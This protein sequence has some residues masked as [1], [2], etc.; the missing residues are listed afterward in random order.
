VIAYAAAVGAGL[1][2]TRRYLLGRL[3]SPRFAR[4]TLWVFAAMLLVMA[5][6][7][8]IIYPR[9]TAGA[10]GGGTDRDE[11]LNI[12]VHELL[13]GRY[14]YYPRTYLNGPISPLPGSLL[15]A[16]PF[17]LL[18]ESAYQNLFW[19]AATFWVLARRCGDRSFA[20]LVIGSV[21]ALSP[22][23]WQELLT[24][25]DLL[26]NSLFVFVFTLLA[27]GAYL[28]RDTPAWRR[29]AATLLLGLSLSSRAN[30]G[31]VLLPLVALHARARGGRS[32]LGH[33]ALA[34]ATAAVITV[35]FYLYDPAGFSPLHTLG[36]V[37]SLGPAA[38]LLAIAA[39]AAV[40]LLL[41]LQPMHEIGPRF[42]LACAGPQAIPVAAGMALHPL[43]GRSNDVF[44]G[45][46][47]AFVWFGVT[48]GWLELWRRSRSPRHR[49]PLQASNVQPSA[50]AQG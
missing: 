22:L 12:G 3:R 13:A 17:V 19:V 39:S 1:V 25:G 30:Y 47:F 18:G 44:P 28:D 14:P 24:G 46:G 11:A 8:A 38:G 33:A 35:P 26:A 4:A 37:R 49:E 7:F 2:G 32:A 31:L 29:I 6:S 23:F 5:C 42:F 48:A 36:M 9:A 20:L 10:F 27:A 45:Y 41:A 21:A 34:C 40:A 43:L 50:P 16:A 15:L